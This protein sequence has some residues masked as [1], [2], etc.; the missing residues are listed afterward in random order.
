MSIHNDS[1]CEWDEIANMF[2]EAMRRKGLTDEE[3]LITIDKIKNDF[4]KDS[5]E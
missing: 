3:I 5:E 1:K 2:Q 4:E